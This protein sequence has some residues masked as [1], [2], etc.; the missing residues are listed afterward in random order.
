MKKRNSIILLFLGLFIS[1][2]GFSL[3][4]IVVIAKSPLPK[5][6]PTIFTSKEAKALGIEMDMKKD[7]VIKVLGAPKKIEEFPGGPTDT[8][9]FHYDFGEIHFDPLDATTVTVGL[10]LIDRPNFPG[11]RNIKV[12]DD[13]ESVIHKFPY[14]K[15]SVIQSGEKYIY[16]KEGKSSGRII[17]DKKKQI[18]FISY[19]DGVGF[20]AYSLSLEVENNKVKTIKIG[21]MNI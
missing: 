11:P 14:N 6:N 4:D 13:I 3:D 12:N 18:K 9:I 16:G 19:M 17:Y 8:L 21:V 2:L 7:E 1:I 10:I 5:T 15:N 20:G